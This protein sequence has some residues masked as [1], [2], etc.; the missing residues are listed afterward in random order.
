[1]NWH[2]TIKQAKTDRKIWN[3]GREK[4][5]ITNVGNNHLM[6]VEFTPET[7]QEK[8]KQKNILQCGESTD[9]TECHIQ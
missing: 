1:M 6:T 5:E 7:T 9:N 8:R 3:D 4:N 2:I